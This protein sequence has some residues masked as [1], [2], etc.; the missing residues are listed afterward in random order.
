M[1]K[2]KLIDVHCSI[3]EWNATA[4][5]NEPTEPLTSCPASLSAVL[6]IFWLRRKKCLLPGGVRDFLLDRFSSIRQR[7]WS[8]KSTKH[9]L[10]TN[11]QSM[12]PI[13]SKCISIICFFA[14][15]YWVMPLGRSL[16]SL[17]G[18]IGRWARERERKRGRERTSSNSLYHNPSFS[19]SLSLSLSLPRLIH[20]SLLVRIMTTNTQRLIQRYLYNVSFRQGSDF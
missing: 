10:K 9:L 4:T 16:F 2:M 15:I 17:H 12:S 7:Q 8:D 18:Y 19:R 3:S 1:W 5:E 20:S 13:E 6:I 14:V 11:D